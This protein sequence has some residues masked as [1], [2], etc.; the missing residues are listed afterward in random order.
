MVH[1]HTWKDACQLRSS[2]LVYIQGEH[3]CS[4]HLQ[5]LQLHRLTELPGQQLGVQT[6][7]S[8]HTP[9]SGLAACCVVLICLPAALLLRCSMVL[10]HTVTC[11]GAQPSY[12][13]GDCHHA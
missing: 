8:S 1:G 4:I 7:R 11:S 12:R 3:H 13:Q 5:Q 6:C 10:C 9:A 2:R